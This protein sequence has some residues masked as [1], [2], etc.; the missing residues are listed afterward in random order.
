M[1]EDLRKK[2]AVGIGPMNATGEEMALV[3]NVA[4]LPS[5]LVEKVKK[6]MQRFKREEEI[7]AKAGVD[8]TRLL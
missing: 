4:Y 8:D 6:I 1:S 5:G 2:A 7:F 3:E